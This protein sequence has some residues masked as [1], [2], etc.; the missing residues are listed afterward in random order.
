MRKRRILDADEPEFA[1]YVFAQK[2]G[3]AQGLQL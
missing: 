3:N 2:K 1:Y